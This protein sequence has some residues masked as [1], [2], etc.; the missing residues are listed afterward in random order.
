MVRKYG[1]ALR[2]RVV[3]LDV[4]DHLSPQQIANVLKVGKT[5]V[6]GILKLY[7]ET[8]GVDYLPNRAGMQRSV[9]GKWRW[10]CLFLLTS[11]LL[12]L[13]QHFIFVFQQE[14]FCSFAVS[15]G[16]TL[17]YIWTNCETGFYSSPEN[18][19]RFQRW[20]GAC[21]KSVFLSRRSVHSFLWIR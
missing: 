11:F 9:T 3:F 19:T 2:W 14:K 8:K 13:L 15:S 16:N 4:I 10:W 20:A 12:T 18:L 6:H 21:V 17:S 5:L 1:T 7:R